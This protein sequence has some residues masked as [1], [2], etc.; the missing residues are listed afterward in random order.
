MAVD[1]YALLGVPRNAS[2]ED[3][4]K[5]FRRLARETHPD[6]NPGDPAAEAKFRQVAEAYEVLSDPDRRRR[7]DRG[8]TIDLGDLFGGGFGGFDDLL[9]SVFGDSG[10]FTQSRAPSR[11]RGRDILARV[12]IDLSHAAFGGDAE[13]SFRTN[14]VCSACQGEGAEPGSSRLECGGCNGTGV[15][16]VARRSLLGTVQTVGTCPTCGGSGDVIAV[17]CRRCAGAGVHSEN[18]TVKVEVPAGVSTGTRL[19]LNREGEAAPRQGIP[20]DL[21]VEIVVRPDPRFERDGDDLLHRVSVGVA[22]AALGTTVDIPTLDGAAERLSIEPGT[23]PGTVHRITGR[24][25]SRLGRRGRGDLVVSISVEVPTDL[26]LEEE[27]LLRR[28]AELR[29]E[30]PIDGRRRRRR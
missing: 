4:K 8:D 21:Y 10:L 2:V 30:N 13:V 15:V 24:G 16:R 3:I 11:P 29:K 1:Y 22:E 18:R 17:P 5:A 27:D 19:R 9:R 6:A 7:Y 26:S 28:F 20:G 23:Q 14:I 25:M 12:E